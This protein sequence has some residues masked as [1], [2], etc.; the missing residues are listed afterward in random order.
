MSI[1]TKISN[2]GDINQSNIKDTVGE[3]KIIFTF[4]EIEFDGRHYDLKFPI[5]CELINNDNSY[6]LE[7]SSLGIFAFGESIE[8]AK[9][10][11]FEEFDYIC[12]RYNSLPIDQLTN[13][14]LSIKGYLNLIVK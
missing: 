2:I 14:V 4:K 9:K 6:S 7:N 8:E 11:F 10:A 1:K 3:A 5:L 12:T 13:D